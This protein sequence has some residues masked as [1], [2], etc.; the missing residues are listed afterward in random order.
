MIWPTGRVAIE[1]HKFI[2]DLADRGIYA[3]FVDIQYRIL[4]CVHTDPMHDPVT[5]FFAIFQS[6][7]S[8]QGIVLWF[9]PEEVAQIGKYTLTDRRRFFL[10]YVGLSIQSIS[11]RLE[12]THKNSVNQESWINSIEMTL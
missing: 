3:Y 4:V 2:E 12:V 6:V 1:M 11:I 9:M 7:E 5:V 10:T 8:D